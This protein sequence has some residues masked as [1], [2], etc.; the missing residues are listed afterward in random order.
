MSEDHLTECDNCG[1]EIPVSETH[2]CGCGATLCPDCVCGE[3]ENEK[4]P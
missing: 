4:S 2:G 3:C 1:R